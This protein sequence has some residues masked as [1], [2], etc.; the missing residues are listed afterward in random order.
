[1]F[2]Y[3]FLGRQLYIYDSEEPEEWF[4]YSDFD[5]EVR[6]I[7]KNAIPTALQKFYPDIFEV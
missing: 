2:R 5:A 6:K 3:R 7:I 1:M 4:N